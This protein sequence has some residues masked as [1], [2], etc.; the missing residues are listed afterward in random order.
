[1]TNDIV[2]PPAPQPPPIGQESKELPPAAKPTL[3]KGDRIVVV[4]FALLGILGSVFLLQYT[5]VPPIVVSFFLSTGLY[6]LV[7]GFLGGIQGATYT[8]GAL[9]LG[10][11]MAVLVGLAFAIHPT[12]ND[13]LKFHMLS[14]VAIVGEWHWVYAKESWEG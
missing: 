7:Y 12:L 1:M 11:T 5:S 9:K 6:A 3:L 2:R 10:G 4:V 14:D 13:D 8:V